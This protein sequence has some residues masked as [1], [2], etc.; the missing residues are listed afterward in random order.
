MP[1]LERGLAGLIV[2]QTSWT[3]SWTESLSE[4]FANPSGLELAHPWFLLIAPLGWLLLFLRGRS[5]RARPALGFPSVGKLR[6]LPRTWRQRSLWLPTLL[7]ALALLL[8]AI[9]AARPR[10]GEEQTL[11]RSEGIAIQ[12]VLDRSSSMEETMEYGE[13]QRKRIDIVKDVFVDFIDGNQSEGGELEGRPTDLI[14]L[15]TF[16]RYTEESCPLVTRHEPLIAAVRRIQTVPAM[17]DAFGRGYTPTTRREYE[18]ALQQGYKRNDLNATAIG[19]GLMRSV[20]SL[21]GADAEYARGEEEGGYKIQSKVIVLLTDGENN[22]GDKDPREA[23]RFARENG[24]R[25]YYI[26]LRE[27]FEMQSSFFGASVKREIPVDQL[28]REPRAVVGKNG[29]AFLATSGDALAK[30]YEEID[31]LE[32]SEVG[33]VEYSSYKELFLWFLLGGFACALLA[34]L[35]AETVYRRIP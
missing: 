27:P 33:R 10:L 6:S 23:G 34:V 19:D 35:L 5:R 20:Y 26:L 8:L 14:G 17:V 15:T 16:A 21:V 30:I 22:A 9:A 2:A 13:R 28:L 1:P 24:I 4:L 18:S 25:L 3:E 29:R 11:L 12:M 32:R 31:E 7:Q